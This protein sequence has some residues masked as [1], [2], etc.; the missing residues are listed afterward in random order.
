MQEALKQYHEALEKLDEDRS[1]LVKALGNHTDY[2]TI[3]KGL[4]KNAEKNYVL[5]IAVLMGVINKTSK[6]QKVED[7]VLVK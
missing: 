2:E 6:S 3:Y 5:I 7:N 1:L 4:K